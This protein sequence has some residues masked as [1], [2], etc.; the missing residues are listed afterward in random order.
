MENKT[1][2]ALENI[3]LVGV[4]RGMKQSVVIEFDQLADLQRDGGSVVMIIADSSKVPVYRKLLSYKKS[5]NK[6]TL[7]ET[8]S[9]RVA[10]VVA[11]SIRLI[12]GEEKSDIV[13]NYTLNFDDAHPYTNEQG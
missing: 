11:A 7:E 8:R 9:S 10:D 5:E 13:M 1:G 2:I 3:D 12:N 4:T 6:K